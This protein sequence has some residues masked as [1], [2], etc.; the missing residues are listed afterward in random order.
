MDLPSLG[1]S[2]SSGEVGFLMRM[3]TKRR[4][5]DV[6]TSVEVGSDGASGS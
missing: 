1:S 6:R 4:S 3:S 2:G 5:G